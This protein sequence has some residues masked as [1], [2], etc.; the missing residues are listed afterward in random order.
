MEVK[1]SRNNNGNLLIYLPK[2]QDQNISK[3][4]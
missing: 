2:E 4:K 3:K 1:D